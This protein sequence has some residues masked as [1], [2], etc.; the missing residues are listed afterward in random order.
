MSYNEHTLLWRW[1]ICVLKRSMIQNKFYWLK[2]TFVGLYVK[3]W[4]LQQD[5]LHFICTLEDIVQS[6]HF[7]SKL[8]YA[9]PRFMLFSPSQKRHATL[10]ETCSISCINYRQLFHM[11]YK[12]TYK[13]YKQILR[14]EEAKRVLRSFC[15]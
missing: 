11:L 15:S 13:N 8:I 10:R 1:Q 7:K 2:N 12:S 4:N 3:E 14:F 5:N 6:N 9:V